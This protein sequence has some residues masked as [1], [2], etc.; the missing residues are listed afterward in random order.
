MNVFHDCWNPLRPSWYIII[1]AMPSPLNS[2][3]V[4]W[5]FLRELFYFFQVQEI[6]YKCFWLPIRFLASLKAVDL[7]RDKYIV[8][9]VGNAQWMLKWVELWIHIFILL[10]KDHF[11]NNI[12]YDIYVENYIL[13]TYICFLFINFWTTLLMY[14]PSRLISVEQT[15]F[16][17]P[18][19]ST[20]CL[21]WEV[22][23]I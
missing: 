22:C 18:E 11:I 19:I 2:A 5:C 16:Q 17:Y 20:E 8:L 1:F 13:L 6:I 7:H 23:K 10:N 14:A 15:Y 4:H 12:T 9:C 3:G 21:V